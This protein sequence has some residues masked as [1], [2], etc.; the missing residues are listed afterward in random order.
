MQAFQRKG[1]VCL[2][3]PN[4]RVPFAAGALMVKN[5]ALGFAAALQI[6][7]GIVRLILII[8]CD[9]NYIRCT[10]ALKRELT[11]RCRFVP[12]SPFKDYFC[13]IACQGF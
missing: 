13:L 5:Y 2:R 9:Q 11:Y 3:V 4:G 6:N 8:G 1:I 10:V 7:Q 12:V